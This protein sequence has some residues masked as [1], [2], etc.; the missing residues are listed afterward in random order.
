[1]S[2]LVNEAV[3]NDTREYDGVP[4][5]VTVKGHPV[6]PMLVNYPIAFL[7]GVL[8]F[9]ILSYARDS[10]F[11]ASFSYW[12]L[13]GGTAMGVAAAAAGM[14]DFFGD[15]R[16]SRLTIA[17]L[18]FLGNAIVVCLS[19]VN[20]ALRMNASAGPVSLSWLMLSAVV[21][22]LISGTGWLGG[23]MVYRHRIGMIPRGTHE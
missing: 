20:L 19:L 15:R 22:L 21:V 6:H 18:H 7:S 2:A 11:W 8:L 12:L 9:D 1:M 4:A 10:S 23:E 13:V 3:R 17:R 14:A 16:I 5:T